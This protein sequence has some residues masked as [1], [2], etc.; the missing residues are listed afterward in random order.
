[1]I[2]FDTS[3]WSTEMLRRRPEAADAIR[4]GIELLGTESNRWQEVADDIY[5]AC[6]L[7]FE[8]VLIG[9]GA[10]TPESILN[11]VERI[12]KAAETIEQELAELGRDALPLPPNMGDRS[13]TV[14]YLRREIVRAL[15]ERLVPP[16]LRNNDASPALPHRYS[17]S[18]RNRSANLGAH[19]WEGRFQVFADTVKSILAY[20]RNQVGQGGLKRPANQPD[21]EAA[22]LAGEL[23]D[24]FER[25][26]SERAAIWKYK[27][28]FVDRNKD[29]SDFVAFAQ[30]VWPATEH[31]PITADT[32]KSAL[33]ALRRF[34]A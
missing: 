19:G 34:P 20:V 8:P 29:A 14:R 13:H 5:C 33:S 12:A 23:R 17:E 15:N 7:H 6:V 11:S 32:L 2:T 26:T 22:R 16:E 28:V 30:A 1:M 25:E 10:R 9:T 27:G 31:A 24:I 3:R 21:Y 18:Y 4:A